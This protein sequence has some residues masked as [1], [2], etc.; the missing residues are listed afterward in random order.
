MNIGYLIS[1][2]RIIILTFYFIL[3]NHLKYSVMSIS[4]LPSAL[5]VAIE[6]ILNMTNQDIRNQIIVEVWILILVLQQQQQLRHQLMLLGL[7]WFWACPTNPSPDCKRKMKFEFC[8][9]LH[10]CLCQALSSRTYMWNCIPMKAAIRS[11]KS[12]YYVVFSNSAIK[13][14]T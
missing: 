10:V 13:S 12:R 7:D 11:S 9:S 5:L 6:Y 14:N 8:K 1:I 3:S 2:N 4:K